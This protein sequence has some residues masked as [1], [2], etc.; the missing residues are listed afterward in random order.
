M[1]TR[2]TIPLAFVVTAGLAFH[3]MAEDKKGAAA[4]AAAP[5]TMAVTNVADIKFGL[6]DPKMP[7]GPQVALVNGDMKGPTQFFLKMK[8]GAKSGVHSHTSDYWAVV[9]QGTPSHG[10]SDK[11]PG[12][13][14]AAGS[15]WFQP[16]GENHHDQCTGATD[17]VLFLSFTGPVDMKPAATT[18]AA[19]TK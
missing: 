9:V 13:P 14:L 6:F 3:A 5:K 11:D 7:D 16:G 18:T 2:I 10:A 17:C 8:P 1:L 12:K 15:Y 19:K 4:P